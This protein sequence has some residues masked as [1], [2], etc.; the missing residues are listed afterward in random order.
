M[1]V[2]CQDNEQPVNC[3]EPV[4]ARCATVKLEP[5]WTS[6]FLREQQ[7]ADFD[8]KVIIGWKEAGKE[9]P[10]WEEVSPQSCAVKT[11][12]SQWDRLLFRNR[13]LCRK[14]ESDGGD[15]IIEQVILPESLRQAALEAHHS[16]TTAIIVVYGRP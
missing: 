4:G 6:T 13:L 15:Q 12:R 1:H 7:D 3:E 9:K 10:L 14:W 5:T 2:P 11:L 8:P 16:H